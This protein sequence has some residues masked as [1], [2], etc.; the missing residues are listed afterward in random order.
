MDFWRGEAYSAYFEYLE[1]KGGFYYEVCAALDLPCAQS[2][3]DAHLCLQKR[4]GD[5]PVHSIGAALFANASQI[6][7]FKDI[8]YRHDPFQHCPTG[9]QHTEGKC[10]CDPDDNFGKPCSHGCILIFS[11]H[12]NFRSTFRV[13]DY[14]PNSCMRRFEEVLERQN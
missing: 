4:W 9:E 7:I 1:S 11:Y 12:I 13:L 8:G 3:R 2:C 6:H 14:A 10:W 5:A